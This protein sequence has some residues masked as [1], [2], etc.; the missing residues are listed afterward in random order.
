MGEHR[1]TIGG[2]GEAI[3]NRREPSPTQRDKKRRREI[4]KWA[5]SWRAL[6]IPLV[7]SFFWARGRQCQKQNKY[8]YCV[9]VV[10]A[11]AGEKIIILC[12]FQISGRQ[13]WHLFQHSTTTKKARQEQW[14]KTVTVR[15]RYGERVISRIARAV[16]ST[17]WECGMDTESWDWNWAATQSTSGLASGIWEFETWYWLINATNHERRPSARNDATTSGG[18]EY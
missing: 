11:T 14:H 8:T 1:R 10:I 15:R 18:G 6:R 4:E 17:D 7:R 3:C 5:L 12:Y 16:R 9:V 13:Q 2:G